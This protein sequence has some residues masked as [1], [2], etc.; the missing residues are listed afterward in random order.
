MNGG[1]WG[2]GSKK[3]LHPLVP[4]ILWVPWAYCYRC[5]FK[6]TYPDCDVFC[7]KF[8]EEFFNDPRS[9]LSEPAGIITEPMQGAGGLIVPPNKFLQTLRKICDKEGIPL[10]FDEVL[11]AWG[12]TG[13]LFGCQH[14]GVTPDIMGWGKSI[15]GGIPGISAI[16]AK[17]ELMDKWAE[18]VHGSTFGG[19][20]LSCRAA[21][22]ALEVIEEEKLVDNSARLG[23]YLMKALKD[24][25]EEHP[26]MGDIRGKGLFIGIEMV[27]DRDTKEPYS[28]AA[29]NIQRELQK[30]EPGVLMIIVGPSKN[31][32]RLLPPLVIKKEEIDMVIDRLQVILTKLKL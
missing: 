21:L 11:T 3:R 9:P 10:I 25:A 6:L 15:G 19:N 29:F 28:E 13:K 12:R 4:G 18:G 22:A 8:V 27:K 17:E 24:L 20:P 31:I 14:S 1:P 5:S 26:T 32:L 16:I 2:R 30:G 7:A 23:D